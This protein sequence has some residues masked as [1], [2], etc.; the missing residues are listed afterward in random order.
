MESIWFDRDF[1]T[2][3]PELVLETS[4]CKVKPPHSF[5]VQ[6]NFQCMIAPGQLCISKFRHTI[7]LCKMEKAFENIDS[8]NKHTNNFGTQQGH[9]R[10][11]TIY[12]MSI[13]ILQFYTTLLSWLDFNFS[14]NT[15]W[16]PIRIYSN[17]YM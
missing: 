5:L 7:W 11:I 10:I 1:Y 16:S 4:E 6:Q 17:W 9:L 14:D 3:Y 13:F 2:N 8:A 12:Q 15:T